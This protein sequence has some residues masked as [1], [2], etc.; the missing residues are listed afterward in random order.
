MKKVTSKTFIKHS[1][2]TLLAVTP[3]FASAGSSD[4]PRGVSGT[5][6]CGGNHFVRDRGTESQSTVFTIR[7][8]DSSLPVS[9][10]RLTVYDA[11]GTVIVDYDGA[12]LPLAF[13][14]VI[15]N[16]DNVI[17]PF[18]TVQYRT[19]ELVGAALPTNRR[20]IQ[21][22]IEWSADDKAV[23]PA[24]TAIRLAR[25]LE[26]VINGAG[27][28]VVRTRGERSRSTGRCRN[29]EISKGH[30]RGHDDD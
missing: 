17:E 30:K 20:P 11:L 4:E 24:T 7:N 25:T 12:T 22:R 2:V 3:M 10:N 18:Q 13:N 16:G 8:T 14:S 19:Q 21:T 26:T 6:S 29:I 5:I 23:V 1:L 15:G 9:I 27:Q 28:P